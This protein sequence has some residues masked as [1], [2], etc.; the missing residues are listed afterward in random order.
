MIIETRQNLPG[1]DLSPAA[2]ILTAGTVKGQ[3][4]LNTRSASAARFYAIVCIHGGSGMFA[5]VESSKT[6]IEAGDL[7]LLFPGVAHEYGASRGGRWDPSY[8]TFDG[9]LFDS[10]RETCVVSPKTPVVK[11]LPDVWQDRMLSLVE[12]VSHGRGT[13]DAVIVA[14]VLSFLCEV[15]SSRPARPLTVANRK[16]VASVYEALDVAA[17]MAVSLNDVAETLGTGYASMLKR[18]ARLTGESLGRTRTR[19]VMERAESL[20]RFGALSV[21]QIA[22]ELGYSDPSYFCRSF[23]QFTGLTPGEYRKMTTGE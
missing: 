13:P 17:P 21:T 3:T 12:L 6:D 18:F 16:W 1:I 5:S 23:R 9:Q 20:L 10:L 14:T 15:V 7:F 8:I 19:L 11:A 2:R 22:D 4:H